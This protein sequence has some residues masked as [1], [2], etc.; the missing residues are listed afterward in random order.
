MGNNNDD[1]DDDDGIANDDPSVERI[2][3]AFVTWHPDLLHATPEPAAA[4]SQS[5][6]R[7]NGEL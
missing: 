6:P 2:V 7:H 1:D 5:R 4:T 3:L